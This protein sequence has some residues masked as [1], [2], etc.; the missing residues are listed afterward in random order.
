M[1]E[2]EAGPSNTIHSTH[3]PPRT[4]PPSA[5]SHPLP[6][7]AFYSVEY[8][9]YVKSTSVPLAVQTLGGQDTIDTVFKRPSGRTNSLVELHLRPEDP[10]AH[11]VAG[12]VVA[13]NN[14]LLKVVKRKRIQKQG[15]KA[16]E[17]EYIA[18]AIGVIPKTARFRSEF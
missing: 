15:Q 3:S 17:G 18:E 2:G 6:S 13:T 7:T 8:P 11:P 5:P 9:G 16:P 12:E 14:I 4:E 1:E 10:F